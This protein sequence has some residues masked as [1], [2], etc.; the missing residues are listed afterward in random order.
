MSSRLRFAILT[1]AGVAVIPAAAT[2]QDAGGKEPKTGFHWRNRPSIQLG[3]L[4]IDGRL[5]LQFD[6]RGFDPEIDEDT[7]D[8]RVKR[9]GINGEF[10]N[11][12]EFQIERD[13]NPDGKWRDVYAN[14]RT[15]RQA[16][17]SGGR[18]K[19]PFGLE[20]LTSTTDIDFAF[21]ALVSTT[22]PPARD[23]GGMVHGRFLK[24]GFTYQVGVFK[25]DGDNGRLE[26]TQFATDNSIPN[27]GPSFAG[28]ITAT[29]LRPLAKTFRD[30]RFGFAYGQVT[31][32]EGL[33]SLRGESVYGTEDFFERVYV[34]GRRTRV[35]TEVS[36]TPGP[37]GFAAEWMRAWE[38]RK[39]QGLGDVDLSD[40][41]ATGYYASATVFITGEDKADFSHPRR[42]L[43]GGG[44]G[45]L[46]AG[47]RFDTLGFESAEKNGPAFRNPRAEHILENSDKVWTI[48]VNWFANRWVRVTLNG[49]RE[50]FDDVRRTPI[51]GTAVFWSGVSRLQIA[52]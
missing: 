8:F 21:R 48:G 7:Y 20:E 41:V 10:G 47:V 45:A 6:W 34:N 51:P 1:L 46:E 9:A 14:W 35:G 42:P 12:L 37:L 32:P 52:F 44:I 49:I 38:Q 19:V 25:G 36:Y 3:D 24:R 16:E 28:R 4:R 17:V 30:L 2:A 5:K 18:F 40:V 15:F 22:I 50:K 43:F 27:I 13:L 11:H 29:P 26:E 31:V 23:T 33:N 39:G